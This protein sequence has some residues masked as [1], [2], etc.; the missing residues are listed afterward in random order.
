MATFSYQINVFMEDYGNCSFNFNY[1]KI[2]NFNDLICSFSTI[3]P[4]R[5]ICP[6]SKLYYKSDDNTYKEIFNKEQKFYSLIIRGNQ[7]K[8]A[9]NKEC[10]CP[11]VIKDN[12]KKTK[13]ELLLYLLERYKNKFESDNKIGKP[14]NEMEVIDHIFIQSDNK[15]PFEIVYTNEFE[16][17]GYEKPDYE[18]E[19]IDE[20]YISGVEKGPLQIDFMGS[21]YIQ[22][23]CGLSLVDDQ[24]IKNIIKNK[25]NIVENID[26][27]KISSLEKPIN[28]IDYCDTFELL[29]K[30][31]KLNKTNNINSDIDLKNVDP[32][33]AL[34]NTQNKFMNFGVHCKKKNSFIKNNLPRVNEKKDSEEKRNYY[35][36][37][38][39]KNK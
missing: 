21:L 13:Y 34:N 15:E 2:S 16:I 1:N 8:I 7:Y 20:I 14:H 24:E 38:N 10:K 33:F 17:L 5:D 12:F 28:K 27:I 35:R 9:L 3:Y 6:C 32:S 25:N 4:E 39:N 36:L 22:S 23:E 29:K 30:E 19:Y 18:S 26:S 37:D 11:Q 31:D